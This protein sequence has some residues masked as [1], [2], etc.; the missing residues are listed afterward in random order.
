M[1]LRLNTAK[2]NALADAG[3]NGLT[4]L[5]IY[6]GSQ[7]ASANSAASGTL[8]GTISGI[9]WA[10]A[11]SGAAALSAST[12]DSSAD[13]TGT[14]GW[15]RF[16]NAGDTLRVDGAVGAEFTLADTSIVAGGVISLT[17]ATLTMPSGE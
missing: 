11:S 9:T 4:H 8:L 10:A 15:G 2:R 16:R 14:A 17:D 13:A 7:P 6:T 12:D 5:D 1:A 3:V